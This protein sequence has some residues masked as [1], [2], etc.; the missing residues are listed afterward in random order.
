MLP[1]NIDSVINS[2]LPLVFPILIWGVLVGFFSATLLAFEDGIKRLRRL[3]QIPCDRC[4]YHTGNA[5]LRCPVHPLS[6]FSEN[7]LCCADFESVQKDPLRPLS[8]SLAFNRPA[9]NRLYSSM[10]SG[11]GRSGALTSNPYT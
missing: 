8:P 11:Q 5:Y 1:T 10:H 6:A 4:I 2:M 3:H 9:L 7:A